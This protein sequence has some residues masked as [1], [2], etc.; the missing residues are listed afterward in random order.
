MIDF[1]RLFDRPARQDAQLPLELLS[2]GY[3]NW[4]YLRHHPQGDQ[5]L[6]LS[7]DDAAL[8]REAALLSYLAD[9][10]PELPVPRLIGQAPGLLILSYCSGLLPVRLP[11]ERLSER[12]YTHIGVSIGQSLAQVHQLRFSGNGF[13]AADLQIETSLAPF[14]AS[15]L[16]YTRSVLKSSLARSRAGEALCQRLLTMLDAHGGLLDG[17][18]TERLVHS[19]FNLKNLLVEQL[20][21]QWRV[22]ALL[23]W[24]FAHVGAPLSDLGNFFRFQEQLPKPLLDGFLEGYQDLAGK[25]DPDWRAQAYLLDLAALCGFLEQ[26]EERPLSQATA[27]DRMQRTLAYFASEPI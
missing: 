3:R 6:R 1:D 20:D 14:A 17:L 9:K 15:W 25:L 4:N 8:E 7:E 5:V 11:L 10:L 27:I 22:S 16:N 12:D 13:F 19:D 2:G 26:T 24:E 23:D 21:A 18:T